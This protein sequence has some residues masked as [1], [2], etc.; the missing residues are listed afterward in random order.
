MP[1]F[2]DSEDWL[3]PIFDAVVSDLQGSGYFSRVNE[4]ESK[5]APGQDL[6]ADVWVQHI[7][8]SAKYSGL[9]IT[10]ALLVFYIRIYVNML[11]EP[12][13]YIDRSVT[14]SVANLMRRYNADF[15]FEGA[16]T[17][18]DILGENGLPL[19]AEAGYVNIDNK[20]FRAM[21]LTVP[22]IVAD[23]WPQGN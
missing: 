13:D 17:H 22:C 11:Q 10:S 20:M 18:V 16:I 4:H 12:Q 14:K 19:S 1:T 23:V 6:T 5:K 7:G 21:T 9:S 2:D 3:D 15:T 8:P